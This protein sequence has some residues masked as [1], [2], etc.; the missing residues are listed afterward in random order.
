[1]KSHSLWYRQQ[2]RGF[3]LVEL[4]VVAVIICILFVLGVSQS[5]LWIKKSLAS[6]SIG[7]LG[8][9]NT[10]LHLYVAENDGKFPLLCSSVWEAP[11]WSQSVTPY[12]APTIQDA[13]FYTNLPPNRNV[14]QTLLSPLLPRGR[15]MSLGD[16]GANLEVIRVPGQP[17]S[18]GGTTALSVA[19]VNEPSRVVAVME[20]QSI[21]NGLPRGTYYIDLSDYVRTGQAANAPSDRDMGTILSLFCDGHVEAVKKQ[22]FVDNRRQYLLIKPD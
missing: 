18:N 13:S 12:L 7:Q 11:Y 2:R 14:S 1:M 5:R 16:Y 22:D 10:A 19:A 8:Q 9:I 3:S 4:L 15:H 6:R 21:Y 20:A 17:T